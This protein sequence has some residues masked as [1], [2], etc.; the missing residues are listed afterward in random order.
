MMKFS[1]LAAAALVAAPSLASAA[2]IVLDFDGLN[3][4]LNEGPGSYYAGGSGSEGTTGGPNYGITFSPNTI[5][6]CTRPNACANTNSAGNPSGSNVIFFLSGSAATMNVASGFDTGFSFFYSAA[7]VPGVVNVYSGL[8]ATGDLLASLTLPVTGDGAGLPGCFGTNF[9]PYSSIGVTFAGTAFSV[10]F[11]GTTN[12]V[13]FDNI[14]LGSAVAGG[15]P[16]P[17]TWALMI[18]G[19]GAIGGAMRRRQSVT[20]KVRFA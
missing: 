18:L 7:N 1:L 9:C 4:S 19:F 14:T 3:A 13:A 11:G 17:T 20:A 15:V 5:T 12:Q 16:E 8:N 2:P 6:G 10:D